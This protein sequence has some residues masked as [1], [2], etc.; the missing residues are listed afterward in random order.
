MF[1][2]E[3]INPHMAAIP[4]DV[5]TNALTG[6][7]V[8]IGKYRNIGILVSFGYGTA[9]SG[10]VEVKVYQASDAEG[11]GAKV[12]DALETGRIFYKLGAAALTSTGTWTKA[13][14]ATA[15]ETYENTD[16]GEAVGMYLLEILD[17]DL[18]DGFDFIR[19][20]V[21]ATS[22]AKVVAITYLC[23][24]ART[25]AAVDAMETPLS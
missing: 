13:T 24:G 3:M 19:A 10:D 15:D 7:Y 11:T 8:N 4:Q 6:D 17:S 20:D 2:G 9:T 21:S 22:S 23:G 25:C 18:D 5:D 16:S 12:L 14:Q 1:V